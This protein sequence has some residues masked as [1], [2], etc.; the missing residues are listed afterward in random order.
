MQPGHLPLSLSLSLSPHIHQ[1]S[2]LYDLLIILFFQT[3]LPFLAQCHPPHTINHLSPVVW[4]AQLQRHRNPPLPGSLCILYIGMFHFS[5]YALAGSGVKSPES[6][7]SLIDRGVLDC[8]WPNGEWKLPGS[9]LSLRGYLLNK[10]RGKYT[11]A[12]ISRS[13][14]LCEVKHRSILS[15]K[16]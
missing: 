10:I 13:R 12:T 4:L 5:N 3:F 8:M 14:A 11:H 6:I 2:N 9:K 7:G 16:H 1:T 15:K